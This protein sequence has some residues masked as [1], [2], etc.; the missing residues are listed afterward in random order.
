MLCTDSMKSY[1]RPNFVIN[2]PFVSPVDCVWHSWT[3][4]SECTAECGGGN[5][6]RTRGKTNER[7]GGQPCTG[8]GSDI[9][10]CNEEECP[11]TL[12]KGYTNK[13]NLYG[14]LFELAQVQKRMQTLPN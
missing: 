2:L 10:M 13:L 1:N 8:S 14:D 9:E 4:W 6:T 5:R 12:A 7:H 3:Q 11:G